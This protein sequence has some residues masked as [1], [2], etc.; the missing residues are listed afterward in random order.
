MKLPK[1]V[2]H[3]GDPLNSIENTLSSFKSAFSKGAD[4]IEGDFWLTSDNEIVCFHNQTTTKITNGKIKIDITKSNLSEI[5]SIDYFSEKFSERLEIPTIDD[6]FEIIPT[7]KGIFLEIKDKRRN[8]VDI[9]KKKI[10]LI[11]LKQLELKIISYHCDILKYSKQQLPN[12]NTLWIF[13]SLFV[14]EKC[15]NNIIFNRFIQSIKNLEVDGIVLNVESNLN[16]T[17]L[18]RL[19]DLNLEICVYGVNDKSTA[20][21]MIE[22]GVDYVTSDN[23][24]LIKEALSSI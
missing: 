11:E 23:V 15:K 18:R 12:I 16:E 22:L 7:G 1:I 3:R 21:R 6:V 20:L 10:S 13:D 2:A 14:K 9:L 17:I 8:F 5:K 24:S 4:F 19:H